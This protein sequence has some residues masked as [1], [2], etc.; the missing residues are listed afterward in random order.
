MNKAI[1]DSTVAMIFE[2]YKAAYGSHLQ[3]CCLL[4]ADEIASAIDG[5]LVAGELTWYAGSCR[6]THW[7]VEKNGQTIDPMGDDFLSTEEYTGRK[8]IHHPPKPKFQHV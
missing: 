5:E 8:E 3:G 1:Y 2:K 4:I 7:W 6:R